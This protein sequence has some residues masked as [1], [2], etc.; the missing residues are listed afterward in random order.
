MVSDSGYS[1]TLTCCISLP[2]CRVSNSIS[3]CIMACF[4]YGDKFNPEKPEEKSTT[5]K[6]S[7][8]YILLI[9][10]LI[11]SVSI[12]VSISPS[13]LLASRASQEEKFMPTDNPNEPVGE[14]RG[15]FPGRL[16]GVIIPKQLPGMAQ[17]VSGGG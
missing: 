14:G 15:I 16:S 8:L 11:V 12:S 10:C 5:I 3:I 7:L 9:L 1:K 2:A 4:T 6:E 13:D 17:K